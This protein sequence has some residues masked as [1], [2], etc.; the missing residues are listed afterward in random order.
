M[1]RFEKLE[2][3]IRLDKF[4]VFQGRHVGLPGQL[5]RVAGVAHSTVRYAYCLGGVR[6]YELDGATL[7]VDAEDLASHF[8]QAKPGRKPLS[9][10]PLDLPPE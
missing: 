6:K 3:A 9:K 1:S 5:A 2:E 4:P 10:I 7:L 8:R